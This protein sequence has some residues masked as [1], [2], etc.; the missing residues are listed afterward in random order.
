[1]RRRRRRSGVGR[2]CPREGWKKRVTV[3]THTSE[4]TRGNKIRSKNILKG[5]GKTGW[6]G[7]GGKDLQEKGMSHNRLY[8]A[9]STRMGAGNVAEEG[10]ER[11]VE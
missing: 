3:K 6:V 8:M 1:M 10:G 7:T 2:E 11:V 9:A 5:T 4:Q